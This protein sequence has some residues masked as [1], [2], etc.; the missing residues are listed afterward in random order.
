V[1]A[2]NSGAAAYGNG[3]NNIWYGWISD[4][5]K[6]DPSSDM[7]RLYNS[8]EVQSQQF[9]VFSDEVDRLT[10]LVVAELDVEVRKTLC[11]DIVRELIGNLNSAGLPHTLL[12]FSNV[13]R[14]NYYH[15]GE[16]PA[17]L[18]YHNIYRDDWFDSN[19]PTLGGR[20]A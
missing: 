16:T 13:L 1:S 10:D 15:I 12:Q 20:P 8:T 11:Q 17:F 7:R 18:N 14:W 19:D 3:A 2:G 4:V 6:L 5:Q 9:G